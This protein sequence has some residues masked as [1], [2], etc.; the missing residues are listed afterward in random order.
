MKSMDLD[1][2][3][4]IRDRLTA[5]GAVVLTGFVA[6]ASFRAAFNSAPYHWQP[7]FHL[8]ALPRWAQ[9]S[10]DVAFYAYLLWLW[11]IVFSIAKSKER[12]WVAGWG[13]GLLLNPLKVV[14][15]SPPGVTAIRQVQ[16]LS[17]AV[18]FLA[19]VS[20]FLEAEAR[21]KASPESGDLK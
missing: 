14:V 8:G 21:D 15:S 10:I 13:P 17:L 2:S 7:F 11:V 19:A 12:I 1:K 6:A 3:G 16:A 5:I 20:I 4:L 9:L 18:A